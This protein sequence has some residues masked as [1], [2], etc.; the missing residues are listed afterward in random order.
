MTRG[1]KEYA[2]CNGCGVCTLSCPIWQQGHDALMT[3]MGR[4]LAL[5]HGAELAELKESVNACMLCG[6]CEPVCSIEIPTVDITLKLRSELAGETPGGWHQ[7]KNIPVSSGRRAS[8]LPGAAL[9]GHEDLLKRTAALLGIPVAEDDGTDILEAFEN[10]L[11]TNAERS[12]TFLRSLAGVSR[13]IV[14]DG[15]M[16]RIMRVALPELEVI[17]LGEALL[18][19][20]SVR[21]ALGPT[22]LYII[23]ARAYNADFQRC[24]P[25][26]TE[27]SRQ[28]GCAMNMDLQRVAIPTGT[29]RKASTKCSVS[30][31]I[32]QQTDWI[33]EG[34]SFKRIVVEAVEDI[35]LL[36]RAS[37][38]PV[39]HAAELPGGAS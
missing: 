29:C 17:G 14:A 9:R 4:A 24:A 10:G 2:L 33:L 13:L 5:Q 22:D 8:L 18:R 21:A 16:K 38:V 36:S 3:F 27:V 11:A 30:P 6:S 1:A 34:M 35:E 7:I 32:S 26:Y 25:F 31:Q 15:L 12:N 20:P 39:M 23:E 19:L 37:A 28:T